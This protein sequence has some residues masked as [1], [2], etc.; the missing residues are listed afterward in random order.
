MG[1]WFPRFE[2][3]GHDNH[4]EYDHLL[5]GNTNSFSVPAGA[6]AVVNQIS[7]GVDMITVR[8]DYTCGGP[9]DL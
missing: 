6:A 2:L 8:L 1:P 5:M 7:Q 9:V 3:G 4:I